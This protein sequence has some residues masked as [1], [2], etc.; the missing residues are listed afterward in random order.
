M[1][2]RCDDADDVAGFVAVLLQVTSHGPFS[3][4]ASY[5][6]EIILHLTTRAS[7]VTD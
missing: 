5:D 4:H 2:I 7:S 1:K 6:F 3:G